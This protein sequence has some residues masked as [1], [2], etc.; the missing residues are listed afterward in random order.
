[1]W[2]T[3]KKY[4]W[5]AVCMQKMYLNDDSILF[6]HINELNLF[7]HETES[8]CVYVDK[9]H[10]VLYHMNIW[11]L[12][13]YFTLGVVAKWSKV[14]TAVPYPLMVWS[15]LALSTYQLRFGSWVFHVIFSFIH[16]NSLYTLGGLH[17]FRKPLPY[18]MYLLNLR[19][20][21]HILIIII[22]IF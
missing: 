8:C 4:I 14:L 16:F 20:A 15:T 3:M 5:N 9:Y 7:G 1:M 13:Y 17:A 10:S 18:N 11:Q 6:K 22:K 21:N 12:L 2:P 19:I